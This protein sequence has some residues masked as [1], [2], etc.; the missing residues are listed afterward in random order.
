VVKICIRFV[1]DWRPQLESVRQF[2]LGR[3]IAAGKVKWRKASGNQV[4]NGARG[5]YVLSLS[6]REGVV[7]ASKMMAPYC[8]KKREELKT[9]LDYFD[10]VITGDEVINRI[11]HEVRIGQRSGKIKKSNIPWTHSF[12]VHLKNVRS[13]RRA[14]EGLMIPISAMKTAAIWHD[15]YQDGISLTEL[16]KKHNLGIKALRRVLNRPR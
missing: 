14:R 9:V 3:G 1:D 5:V 4:A 11:N 13:T 12:G 10:D 15:Y 2:L 6:N 7:M 8:V 16:S